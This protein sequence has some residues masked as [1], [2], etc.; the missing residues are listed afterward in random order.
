MSFIYELEHI[1]VRENFSC[2]GVW[3]LLFEILLGRAKFEGV[4]ITAGT[5]ARNERALRFYKELGFRQISTVLLLD[6]KKR[7]I[8]K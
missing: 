3:K 5:L 4:N 1:V 7:I 8:N 2:L 6:L